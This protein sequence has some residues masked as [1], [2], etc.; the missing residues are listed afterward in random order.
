[1][2]SDSKYALT[3]LNITE[4]MISGRVALR[5]EAAMAFGLS[6]F[7]YALPREVELYY[8]DAQTGVPG[9]FRVQV[10]ADGTFALSVDELG[11][12]IRFVKDAAAGADEVIADA[13]GLFKAPYIQPYLYITLITILIIPPM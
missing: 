8:Q 9:T 1:M 7:G 12:N 13:D 11:E 5:P 6:T 4:K 3:E 2:P 10:A